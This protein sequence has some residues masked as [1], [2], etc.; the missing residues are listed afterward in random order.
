MRVGTCLLVGVAWWWWLN[1][2]TK[3]KIYYVFTFAVL[4]HKGWSECMCYISGSDIC[5][6]CFVQHSIFV[7][8]ISCQSTECYT[9]L[10][11]NCRLHGFS[12]FWRRI[13]EMCCII[14][15]IGCDAHINT[16]YSHNEIS[17][18]LLLMNCLCPLHLYER[19]EK[20]NHEPWSTFYD[21]KHLS[22]TIIILYIFC[23]YL[24]WK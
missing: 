7:I 8:Q 11:Q 2:D 14:S 5:V 16:Y 13:R 9:L 24:F 12:P 3:F 6:I 18:I 22:N 19:V 4:P 15:K 10:I 20:W 17:S 1:S 23:N 21:K